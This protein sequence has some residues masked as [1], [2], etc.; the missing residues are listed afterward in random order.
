MAKRHSPSRPPNGSVS[1]GQLQLPKEEHFDGPDG[2]HYIVD[3]QGAA[4]LTYLTAVGPTE[5]EE[6]TF[7]GA[8][9]TMFSKTGEFTDTSLDHAAIGE[10]FGAQSG[11]TVHI[12]GVYANIMDFNNPDGVEITVSTSDHH[13]S[14]DWLIAEGHVGNNEGTDSTEFANFRV[15]L[16]GFTTESEADDERAYGYVS[17]AFDGLWDQGIEDVRI[18]AGD[19]ETDENPSLAWLYEQL[20]VENG[21]DYDLRS[22]WQGY[23]GPSLHLEPPQ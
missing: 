16:Q 23:G 7:S 21:E 8:G 17:R 5:G 12:H 6:H 22:T 3:P 10:A 1:L 13:I 15:E 14:V 19:P 18:N 11:D 20:G 2:V 9:T 4:N